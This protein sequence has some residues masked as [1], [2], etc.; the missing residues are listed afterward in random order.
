MKIDNLIKSKGLRLDRESGI[1]RS[2][3][4]ITTGE[5]VGHDLIVDRVTLEQIEH[6][7]KQ[8]G[9]VPVKVNHKSGV[10]AVCGHLVNFR[11][12]GDKVLADWKLLKS[13]PQ[14]ETIMETV[15][16]QPE[17]VGLSVSYSSATE[18]MGPGGLASARIGELHSVDYVVHP[19]AN[20][21]GLFAA[22]VNGRIVNFTRKTELSGLA[23]LAALLVGIRARDAARKAA[24]KIARSPFTKAAIGGAAGAAG[25]AVV[26]GFP[27]KQREEEE[28][29]ENPRLSGKFL[30]SRGPGK[31]PAPRLLILR[32]RGAQPQPSTSK[33][34]HLQA[35]TDS[36]EELTRVPGPI[37][38]P[39]RAKPIQ[40]GSSNQ[41]RNNDGQ[42]TPG[43]ASDPGTMRQAYGTTSRKARPG[44]ATRLRAIR[45]ATS[46]QEQNSKIQ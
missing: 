39:E 30:V 43:P 29:D 2:V 5:A 28:E 34:I 3:S 20:R 35:I 45:L 44:L 31:S 1:I 40:S 19:A 7:G 33:S 25:A 14:Y 27:R 24:K 41:A 42:F 38:R 12:K 23:P 46:R 10:D 22:R 8:R 21:D 13:H 37:R 26:R 36:I 4:V 9:K 11:R 6:Q 32:G 17:T 18:H 15:E 16:V